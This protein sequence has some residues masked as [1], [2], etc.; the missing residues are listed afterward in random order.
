MSSDDFESI[1]GFDRG[2]GTFLP[3]LG[4]RVILKSLVS[5]GCREEKQRFAYLYFEF[6]VENLTGGAVLDWEAAIK[7][8]G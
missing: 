1:S 6:G 3:F 4:R 2:L 8:S 7:I 5:R